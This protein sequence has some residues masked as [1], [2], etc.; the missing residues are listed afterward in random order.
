[1]Y[2]RITCAP[3][4]ARLPGLWVC[5]SVF[6]RTMRLLRDH[7]WATITSAQLAEA[8]ANG[9]PVPRRTFVVVFDDGNRDGFDEA[10]PILERY[11]FKG[12]FAVVV[13]RV[14]VTRSSMTWAELLEL[15]EAGHEVANHS[16]SH[17][18]VAR[19]GPAGLEREI[20]RSAERLREHLG[21][22]PRTFVYPFGSWDED[23]H[24]VVRRTH[25]RIA[26]TTAPGST[27]RSSDPFAG[28]RVR[29]S[30]G[31]APERILARLSVLD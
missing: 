18:N 30:R 28:P 3:S 20:G 19:L 29:V 4:D 11:G 24:D 12:V 22:W 25:H 13:G 14:G 2:H 9:Q 10:Y 6:D 1:M 27:R 8:R 31:D 15:Q 26:L 17:A 5:P 7:G 21:G 16:M 23:A